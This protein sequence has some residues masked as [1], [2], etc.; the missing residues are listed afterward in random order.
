MFAALMGITVHLLW[1]TVL[2]L[3]VVMGRTRSLPLL[4]L[5]GALLFFL[6][7]NRKSSHYVHV[8][9]SHGDTHT[10]STNDTSAAQPEP[11]PQVFLSHASTEDIW[12]HLNRSRIVLE[13][14]SEQTPVEAPAPETPSRPAWVD[15]PPKRVGNVYREVLTSERYQTIPECHR[16][17]EP[18]LRETVRHRI[19]QLTSATEVPN[20]EQLGVELDYVLRE[21]CHQEW[22]ET[23]EASFGEMKIVHV[24]MEFDASDDDHLRSAMRDHQR[25]SR[26]GRVATLAGSVL[27]SLALLFGLLK[28]DTHTRG[29]YT[30]RLFFGVP[31]AII[32]AVALL[33]LF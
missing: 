25:W 15:T 9:H 7:G 32:A 8:E 11:P 16:S 30:K 31:A 21:I 17:L 14:D 26:V 24:L 22:V 29:Y 27:G 19:E 6:V 3:L 1:P 5:G 20:L 33:D 18:R 12:E 4:L 10:Y 28:A 23:V 13:G 2:L